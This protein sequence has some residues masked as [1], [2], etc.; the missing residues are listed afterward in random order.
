[1]QLINLTDVQKPVTL[2]KDYPFLYVLNDNTRDCTY[3]HDVSVKHGSAIVCTAQIES[4][5]LNR[6]VKDWHLKLFQYLAG[7]SGIFRKKLDDH[8]L[9]SCFVLWLAHRVAVSV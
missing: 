9:T 5:V 1:M 4:R 6:E 3:L 2:F 8:V 7:S